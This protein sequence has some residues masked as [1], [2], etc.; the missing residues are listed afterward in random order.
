MLFPQMAANIMGHTVG[1]LTSLAAFDSDLRA[2]Y[3]PVVSRIRPSA[4][5][6]H[7]LVFGAEKSQRLQEL[8]IISCAE[9]GQ[10]HGL[11]DLH[12]K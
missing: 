3:A 11:V 12:M 4:Q 7:L 8:L 1:P 6:G 5:T 10:R 2:F 9:G